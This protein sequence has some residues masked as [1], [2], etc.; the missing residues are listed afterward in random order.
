MQIFPD[1]GMY[2]Q[3][4]QID[5]GG[6]EYQKS[7]Y[8]SVDLRGGAGNTTAVSVYEK[9]LARECCLYQRLSAKGKFAGMHLLEESGNSFTGC[10]F[11]RT[12]AGGAAG[13]GA[14]KQ[15]QGNRRASVYIPG[16]GENACSQHLQ[17]AWRYESYRGSELLSH[18]YAGV[19]KQDILE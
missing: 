18:V 9:V 11:E 13:T 19:R 3:A 8:R 7:V 15:Q 1:R 17:Q 6:T 16:N 5:T 12:G 4:V 10:R 2:Y 14:G